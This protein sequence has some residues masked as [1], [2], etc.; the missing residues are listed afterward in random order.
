MYNPNEEISVPVA[1]DLEIRDGSLNF[2][3]RIIEVE[4]EPDPSLVLN[5]D[6]SPDLIEEL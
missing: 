5:T 3:D 6:F 4:V 1:H 2:R